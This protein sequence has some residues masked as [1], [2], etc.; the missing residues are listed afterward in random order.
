MDDRGV[1]SFGVSHGFTR[2][3]LLALFCDCDLVSPAAQFHVQFD[4]DYVV[5]DQKH[6]LRSAVLARVLALM[7]VYLPI[8]GLKSMKY[9]PKSKV[10]S[11]I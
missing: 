10:E 5:F 7:L 6:E 4:K 2:K 3:A 11:L 9:V 1:R 8:L